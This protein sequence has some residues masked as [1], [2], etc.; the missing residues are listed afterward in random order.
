MQDIA[1]LH[2]GDLAHR[3]P[4][5][6]FV[7]T[8]RESRF[9][10]PF[11]L[12]VS[13]DEVESLLANEGITAV[14]APIGDRIAILVVG[15][16][17]NQARVPPVDLLAERLR[18]PTGV[19]ELHRIATLPLMPNEKIDRRAIAAMAIALS[20]A[21][22]SHGEG[23]RALLRAAWREFVAILTGRSVTATCVLDVFLEQF[24]D[25]V[26]EKDNSFNALGGD[27]MAAVTF[28]I[29]LEG[30]LGV[31]PDDWPDMSIEQLER[32]RGS[33]LG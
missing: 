15:E 6:L 29:Q 19:F 18:L 28:A 31:L 10:K 30:L 21:A 25:R 11:G 14:A 12:R 23:N 24:G 8:G 32:L 1:V 26:E 33:H 13:L 27:S 17:A 2:T 16:S 5:G 3:L 4:N 20:G 7:I 9:V 22:A